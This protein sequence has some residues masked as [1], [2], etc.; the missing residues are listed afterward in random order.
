M[1]FGVGLG[2]F[3]EGMQGGMKIRTEMDDRKRQKVLD[4]R[5]DKEYERQLKQRD[6]IDQIGLDTRTKFKEEVTAGRAEEKDFDNFFSN[7]A[8]PRMRNEMLLSGDIQ[9][10]ESLTKWGE[11]TSAREGSR[12]FSSALVKAQ[13]GDH[14]G[15]LADA[16]KAGQVQGYMDHGYELLGQ[17]VLQDPTGKQIGFRLRVKKPDG[18]EVDQD[19]RTEDI[20][21]LVATVANPQAAFESYRKNAEASAKDRK[22]LDTYAAKKDIDRRYAGTGKDRVAAI[23]NLRKRMDGGIGEDEPKFDDLPADKKES[24]IAEEI[25]L[26]RGETAPG[27][28]GTGDTS[29]QAARGAGRKV[30]VDQVTGE[31]LPADGAEQKVVADKASAAA[32]RIEESP[33]HRQKQAD[34]KQMQTRAQMALLRLERGEDAAAII[35]DLRSMGVPEELW[36]REVIEAAASKGDAVGLGRR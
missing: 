2:A 9:G 33:E 21:Q 1:S 14:A 5:R 28:G 6:T 31:V 8:L 13:T 12:L 25:S 30:I 20:P 36:P 24:L 23:T 27:L 22:E 34:T 4:D 32:A 11:T 10:A 3:M 18:T 35:A 7:Y 17:D 29:G 15:A 26:M 16:I 19:I